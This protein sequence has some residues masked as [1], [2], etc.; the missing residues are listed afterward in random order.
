MS[1]PTNQFI[2][3]RLLQMPCCQILIC[4]VNPRRPMYC[5]ECGKPVFHHY[6]RG[7]WDTINSPA[8]L[9][10]ENENNAFIA[11]GA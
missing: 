8:T 3:F 11:G 7:K 4:W 6:P 10:I 5:P 1:K 9:R 2:Q